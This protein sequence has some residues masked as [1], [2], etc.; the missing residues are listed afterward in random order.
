MRSVIFNAFTDVE[1]ATY[2]DQ[3]AWFYVAYQDAYI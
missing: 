1:S 2:I 3:V